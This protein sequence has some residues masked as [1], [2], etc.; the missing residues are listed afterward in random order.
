MKGR[1]IAIFT[2]GTLLGGGVG[3]AVAIGVASQALTSLTDREAATGADPEPLSPELTDRLKRLE[4]AVGVEHSTTTRVRRHR[5]ASRGAIGAD[6]GL[7][8]PP[9]G[10]SAEEEAARFGG[11]RGDDEHASPL[12]GLGVDDGPAAG[13]AFVDRVR[14]ALSQIERERQAAAEQKRRDKDAERFLRDAARRFRE[15]QQRLGLTDDEVTRLHAIAEGSVERRLSAQD[16]GA[17][18][19][20]L[21]MLDRTT[22]R[23]VQSVLGDE[24]YVQYRKLEIDRMARPIVANIA[25]H[26]GVDGAQ[27][28]EI[29]GL[30]SEHIDRI[31]RDESRLRSEELPAAERERLRNDV[32]TANREAWRRLREDI[33]TDDQ[34]G[35]MPE[36]FR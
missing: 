15:Y 14:E 22:Q 26:T 13:A 24:R 12:T 21:S 5:G 33:L 18:R 23:E 16:D 1:T 7:E 11:V 10:A 34:R 36:R 6:R 8:L 4:R 9:T 27:R 32:N 17:D 2:L 28:R 25:S 35:R 3:A 30:L 31:A 20:A 19:D 29:E